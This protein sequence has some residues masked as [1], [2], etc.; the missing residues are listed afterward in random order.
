[1]HVKELDLTL[2]DERTLHVYD[3]VPE[4]SPGHL[5][6]IW[7]HGTPNI[8]APPEPL[9]AAADRSGIR[10]V[11]YDRPGYGGSASHPGRDVASAA[12]DVSDIADTLGLS[13]FAVMGH[14]GGGPH[15]L[16]CGGLLPERVIGVVSGSGLAPAGAEGLDWFPLGFPPWRDTGPGPVPAGWP[17]PHRAPFACSMAGQPYAIGGV[18]APPSRRAR[19]GP[20]VRRGRHGL[21]PGPG[22][23]TLKLPAHCDTT[24]LAAMLAISPPSWLVGTGAGHGPDGARGWPAAPLPGSAGARCGHREGAGASHRGVQNLAEPR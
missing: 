4:G 18:A 5:A 21:A 10:W 22:Q 20:R 14:S 9:F 15:A 13:R 11:S 16:A 8:G 17:G 2:G 1:V 12:A 6:I 3:T 7:H 24:Y 19:L 23:R